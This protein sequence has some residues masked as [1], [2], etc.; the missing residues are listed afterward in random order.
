MQNVYLFIQVRKDLEDKIGTKSVFD[1][2]TFRPAD[3]EIQYI[4]KVNGCSLY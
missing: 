1:A 3:T 2:L 4:A